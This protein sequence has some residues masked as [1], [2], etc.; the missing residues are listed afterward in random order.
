[1][2][3]SAQSGP[4]TGLFA[5]PQSR[6]WAAAILLGVL[7]LLLYS[8]ALRFSF[9]N[10]DDDKYVTANPVVK[11]G[12]HE[13][14][15]R[16]ALTAHVVGHWQPVTLWS[17]MLDCELFGSNT[18]EG[19]H[20]NNIV[21]HAAVVLFLFFF[22][23]SVTG[24]IGRSYFVAALF[25]VHPVNIEN[26]AWI[27]ERKTL[28]SA[29]FSLLALAAYR[30]FAK[31][32]KL[33][34]WLLV[35]FW[36]VLAL[37]SKATA[38]TLPVAFLLLDYWP[39]D[40]IAELA[41]ERE[42]TYPRVS[43]K[44][45]IAEKVPMFLLCGVS[46]WIT[47]AG[48]SQ[49]ESIV[50][51]PVGT[52][53]GHA[54]W[55]YIAYVVKLLWPA[56]LSILYPYAADP[57]W[58]VLLGVL[59]FVVISVLVF[60]FRSRRYLVFGW[61]FYVISMLPVIGFIQVG[62]QSYADHFLYLPQAGIFILIAWG[63]AEFLGRMNRGAILKA[64]VGAAILIAAAVL[65]WQNLP[66][67]KNSYTV[68][69]RAEA[70]EGTSDF[71]IENNLAQG[72]VEFGKHREAIPHYQRAIEL[73]PKDPLPRYNLAGNLAYTGDL[74]GAIEQYR[75]ALTCSPDPGLAER[76]LHN[77][78]ATYEKTGDLDKA[79]IAYSAALELNPN[80]SNSLF[81]RAR[82]YYAQKRY[83]EAGEDFARAAAIRPLP[84]AYYWLGKS[85]L[86]DGRRD[87]ALKAFSRA[88]QIDPNFT[89]ARDELARLQKH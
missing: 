87:D 45:A 17:H 85:V 14:S 89:P 2:I 82:V 56:K 28:L 80:G 34:R 43:W 67:W 16:W 47:I 36:F 32:P 4:P 15:I 74:T 68:F 7:V 72:L 76:I 35:V 61:L 48:Q 70:L 75:A 21:L 25:A 11:T 60:R 20:F 65:T 58:K 5:S 23:V 54:I 1:M 22:L 49:S 40:R 31:N 55:S 64:A 13:E 42:G 84:I 77:L 50:P 79:G 44:D 33:W 52:R 57:W 6:K 41:G 39:L 10:Y 78:A 71:V 88:L 29:L 19:H 27:S 3:S 63:G 37:A 46:A 26:V 83:R 81:G 8:P 12:L 51:I 24:A 62:R 73:T 18:P 69:A 53:F 66:Y 38:I 59:G 30:A 86:E 9:L